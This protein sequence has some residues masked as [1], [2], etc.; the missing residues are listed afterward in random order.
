MGTF[1]EEGN[2][3]PRQ[4]TSNDVGDSF[5]AAIDGSLVSV[6]PPSF[7]GRR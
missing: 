7:Q 4:I 6:A 2:Y 5:E 3:I 1:D